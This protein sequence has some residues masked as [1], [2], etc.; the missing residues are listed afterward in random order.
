MDCTVPKIE[1]QIVPKKARNN[2]AKRSFC[3]KQVR[4][5]WNFRD[6]VMLGRRLCHWN[7]GQKRC[8]MC[9]WAKLFGWQRWCMWGCV[10]ASFSMPWATPCRLVWGDLDPVGDQ[11][12]S[13]SKIFWKICQSCVGDWKM[14]QK[15]GKWPE[16][17]K[18]LS[19]RR[20]R[21]LE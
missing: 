7:S 11:R 20:K 3:P 19:E 5:R 10:H 15:Q 6:R 4:W 14:C 8:R 17:R 16:K 2:D 1:N 18:G 13:H 21:S 12:K 9:L